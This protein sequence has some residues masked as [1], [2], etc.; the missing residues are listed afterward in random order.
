VFIA[1]T[2]E[3]RRR[4]A[5]ATESILSVGNPSFS[6]AKFPELPDLPSAAREA[7]QIAAYYNAAPLLGRMARESL[8]RAGMRHADVIQF[9]SHY[10]IDPQSPMQSRLLL[11]EES[12]PSGASPQADGV[13]QTFEIYGMKLNRTRLVVLSAC[14]TG[15]ERSYQGEGA[16]G[17]ARSFISAGVPVVVA[18][19]WPVDSDATAALMIKFHEYRKIN[20]LSSAEALRRAQR[21]M[22]TASDER[23]HQPYA[24]AAFVAFGG[25]T[26]F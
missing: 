23:L 18:S 25:H 9:A 6:R 19:L 12:Q 1:C 7:E 5:V 15:V 2:E 20:G 11:S 4:E 21:D 8:V 26:S 16:I 10:V 14:Q 22:L 17:I 3:A 13:L 24:W